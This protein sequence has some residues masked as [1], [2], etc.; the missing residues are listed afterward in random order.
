MPDKQKLPSQAQHRQDFGALL[1]WAKGISGLAV[2]KQK[3]NRSPVEEGK[4]LSVEQARISKEASVFLLG[5]GDP[6]SLLG[7]RTSKRRPI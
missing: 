5:L 7:T 3:E 1:R 2:V 6:S 4:Q